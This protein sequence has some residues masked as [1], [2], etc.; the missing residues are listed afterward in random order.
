MLTKYYADKKDQ[1]EVDVKLHEPVTRRV[2][3]KQVMIHQ[4]LFIKT[5]CH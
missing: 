5:G 2:T 1:L 3:L 4:N